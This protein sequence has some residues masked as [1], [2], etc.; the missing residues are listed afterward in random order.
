MSPFPECAPAAAA[1]WLGVLLTTGASAAEPAADNPPAP[2]SPGIEAPSEPGFETFV[3]PRP[4]RR[5][6]EGLQPGAS[7]A[8]GKRRKAR[9]GALPVYGR[10]SAQAVLTLFPGANDLSLQTAGDLGGRQYEAQFS[11]LRWLQGDPGLFSYRQGARGLQV[12]SAYSDLLGATQGIRLFSGSPEEGTVGVG[13]YRRLRDGLYS[14]GVPALDG[15]WS[16]RPGWDSGLLLAG[17]ASWRFTQQAE[18]KRWSGGAFLGKDEGSGQFE[19][20]FS[21]TTRLGEATTLYGRF[22]GWSGTATGQYW[23]AGLTQHLGAGIL[24]LDQGLSF[25][26]RSQ[27]SQTG[28]GLFYPL[29]RRAVGLRWQHLSTRTENHPRG[30]R[31]ESAAQFTFSTPL[32]AKTR[33]WL[34]GGLQMGEDVGTAPLLTVGLSRDLGRRWN[35]SA[36]VTGSSDPQANRFRASVG[37]QLNK[38]L[39]LRLLVG[40]SLTARAGGGM[41]ETVGVQV[42]RRVGAVLRRSGSIR[43]QVLVDD[44]PCT[45]AL[46]VVL[47]DEGTVET[48]ARGRFR[49]SQLA[50]GPHRVRLSLANLPV[51]ISTEQAVET[52]NVVH[53]KKTEVT[54]QLHWVGQVRGTVTAAPDLFGRGDP[55]AH[56]GVVVQAETN[57]QASTDGNGAFVLGNLRAGTHRVRLLPETLPRQYEVV[58]PAEYTVEVGPGRPAPEVGFK[59]APRKRTLELSTPALESPPAEPSGA[60]P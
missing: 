43:G 2:P 27:A 32:G 56:V 10:V 47:D 37:Y 46:E 20:G 28:V 59:I 35:L 14:G 41:R 49:I 3:L 21:G 60:A 31:S 52:V 7:R 26:P 30:G 8:A 9:K 11:P 15:R 1:L 24:T 57:A 40:P 55:L 50:P 53:G 29:G 22:A 17:D 48:D 16:L 36:E 5:T 12:G 42:V 51:D 18:A 4:P 6:P 34:G 58:G 39:Q 38:D 54:F 23:Q 45:E 13:L 19:A 44:R 25:Q 33:L